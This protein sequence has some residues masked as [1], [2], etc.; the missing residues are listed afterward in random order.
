MA[1]REFET[2]ELLYGEPAHVFSELVRTAFIPSE[3]CRFVVTDFSAIEARVI[4]WLAGEQWRLDVFEKGGDIYCASASRMFGVPVEKHGVNK[5]LRQ[6]GK[7]AELALGYQGGVGAMKSMD[8]AGAI[9]EAE[10]PGIVSQWREASPHIVK[11][12]KK[13]ETAAIRAVE[14]RR[15]AKDPVKVKITDGV[16]V[17]FYTAKTAGTRSL[18][19][20]LPSGRPICYWGVSVHK[21]KQ[22]GDAL[23]YWGTGQQTK[24]WMI[25]DTYGGKITENIV[26][27][28]AR[29][30]L[31]VKMV[32]AT[33]RGYKIV[34]HVHDE[35]I[36][37]VPKE[38]A[39]AAKT[40]D[41]MM[42]EP[43]A[44]APGLPLKGGTYECEYYKK[45]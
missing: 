8:K 40:I 20:W 4:A 5:H 41:D 29:D 15:T 21:G 25:L 31:A 44:W 32:E 43:I 3:G 11:L 27:A 45:D 42:A 36:L 18:F 38:D 14:A 23:E 19:V 1:A 13:F 35:M 9:P 17:E 37:D 39:E 7:I 28:T 24:S 26:Q 6:K 30:C 22:I 10:L 16:S 2:L 34:A 33:R 12:W